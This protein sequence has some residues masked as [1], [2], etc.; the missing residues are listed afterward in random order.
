MTITAIPTRTTGSLGPTKL[1]RRNISDPYRQMDADE[2]NLAADCLIHLIT[3]VGIESSPAWDSLQ[4]IIK[5]GD[6]YWVWEPFDTALDVAGSRWGSFVAAPSLLTTARAGIRF[7][8]DAVKDLYHLGYY[9]ARGQKPYCRCR[10]VLDGNPDTWAIT[11]VDGTGNEGWGV[12]VETGGTKIRGY[13]RTAG[14]NTYTDVSTWTAS[15]EFVLEFWI[16]S[17][18][19][20]VSKDGAAGTSCGTVPTG[21]MMFYMNSLATGAAGK[22]LDVRNMLILADWSA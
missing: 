4:G 13:T 18:T 2:Y 21:D 16:D 14:V 10:I 22:F 17:N 6:T 11:F 3:Q 1:N 20:Y 19:L 5:S 8:L 15:T 9:F 12:V 7:T